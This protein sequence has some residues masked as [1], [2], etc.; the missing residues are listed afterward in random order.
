VTP[1]VFV[2]I[3]ISISLGSVGQYFFK[4]GMKDQV[5]EMGPQIVL[6]FFKP[7]VFIGLI[8]YAMATV[9]WLAVLSKTSL[10]LAYPFISISYIVVVLMGQFIF[11]EGV[12]WLSWMGVLVIC[13]GVVL[14]GL[15]H[16]PTP[17]SNPPAA[18]TSASS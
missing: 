17:V 11:H 2:L 10:S 13:F 12:S 6:M 4:A 1:K 5:V 18:T 15:G 8:C 7:K 14:V 9:F 16:V 3:L